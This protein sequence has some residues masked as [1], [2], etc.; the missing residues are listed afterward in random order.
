MYLPR[1]ISS[2]TAASSIHG[3]G[4]QSWVNALRKGCRA[5]SGTAFGP[6]FSRRR[7]ASS[8]VSPVAVWTSIVVAI[9]SSLA[10]QCFKTGDDVEEFLVDAILAQSMKRPIE[11]L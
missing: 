5:V 3:T 4:A 10:C 11:V 6:N 1:T 8:L 9:N 7:R 2:T